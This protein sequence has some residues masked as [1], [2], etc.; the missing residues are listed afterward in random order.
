MKR[1]ADT[2]KLKLIVPGAMALVMSACFCIG[3]LLP[4]QAQANKSETFSS[5]DDQTH[6]SV[7][8]VNAVNSV[9]AAGA[10]AYDSADSPAKRW[11]EAVDEK[12][13]SYSKTE[14]E[15]FVLNRHF[16]QE[17][18]RV[19]EWTNTAQAV[20]VKYKHLASKLRNL[21][22]PPGHEDLSEYGK[23]LA[24]YY[25]D[26]AA[27]Y[28]DLTKPRPPAKTMEDLEEQLD[29]IESRSKGVKRMQS[30]LS[31]LDDSLRRK[32]RVH[33]RMDDALSK[34]IFGK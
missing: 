16:N 34:Y 33:K 23:M 27:I 10:F 18:E 14:K 6:K 2:S 1:A 25:D 3:P 12:V 31:H 32:Y 7:Q 8:A 11:F 5:R 15:N 13:I 21:K 19:Q 22:A 4:A 17:L 28:D 29:L 30:S 9:A 26:S 24:D 20:A